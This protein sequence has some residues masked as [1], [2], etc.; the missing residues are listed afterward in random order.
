MFKAYIHLVMNS[1]IT[2][3]FKI[4]RLELAIKLHKSVQHFYFLGIFCSGQ[5]GHMWTRPP[6]QLGQKAGQGSRAGKKC[7]GATEKFLIHN[8]G[9]NREKDCEKGF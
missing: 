6:P 8:G 3:A 7:T 1:S 2:I 9:E 4:I 5:W